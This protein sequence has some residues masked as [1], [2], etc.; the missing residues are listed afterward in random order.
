MPEMVT[1]MAKR[2][3]GTLLVASEN[4]LNVFD[5]STGDYRHLA[6]L[7]PHPPEEPQQ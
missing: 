2:R 7:E 4:G 6:E 1:A 3:D 5:P